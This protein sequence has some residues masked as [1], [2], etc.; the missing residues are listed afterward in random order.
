MQAHLTT[1][2]QIDGESSTLNIKTIESLGV[3]WLLVYINM[4]KYF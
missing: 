4:I 3:Y 2:G 1:G